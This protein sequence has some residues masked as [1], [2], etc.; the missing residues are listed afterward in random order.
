MSA[1]A[2][3]L[4]RARTEAEGGGAP[5]ALL[6]GASDPLAGAVLQGQ[7]QEMASRAGASLASAELLPAEAA[8][9]YRRIG[10]RVAVNGSWPAIVTLL[11]AVNE[12]TPRMLVVELQVRDAP[13]IAPGAERPVAAGLTVIAFRADRDPAP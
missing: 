8:G 3:T 10:L 6:E 9:R 11:R 4:P 5:P 13:S 1:I 2:G 12:A 7:V